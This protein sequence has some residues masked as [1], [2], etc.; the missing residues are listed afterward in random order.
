MPYL[1]SE[2]VHRRDVVLLLVHRDQG[3]VPGRRAGVPVLGHGVL[4]LWTEGLFKI[5]I[6][7]QGLSK[8]GQLRANLGTQNLTEGRQRKINKKSAGKR[9]QHPSGEKKHCSRIK[10]NKC[11]RILL[12]ARVDFTLHIYLFFA[13]IIIFLLTSVCHC[14]P[15]RMFL[16]AA[17]GPRPHFEYQCAKWTK[18]SEQS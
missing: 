15:P 6:L 11:T 13:I 5:Y 3:L 18:V 8:F 10:T 17:I 9:R 1:C 16:R 7:G 12:K 14:G 2:Q 4:T